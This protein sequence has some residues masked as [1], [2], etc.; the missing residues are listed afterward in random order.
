MDT[1]LDPALAIVFHQY[2]LFAE[3]QYH[4]ILRSPEVSRLQVYVKRKKQEIEQLKESLKSLPQSNS[5]HFRELSQHHRKAEAQ[6]GEDVAQISDRTDSQRTFLVQAIEMYSRCLQ[7]SDSFDDSAV[8]RLCSLWFANFNETQMQS[9]FNQA[10]HRVPSHKFIFLAHQLSARLSKPSAGSSKPP[11]NQKHLQAL[12]VRMCN[13]HPFHSLY[14]VWALQQGAPDGGQQKV[15]RHSTRGD[16]PSLHNGRTSAAADI[17]AICRQHPPNTHRVQAIE[18][19]CKAYLEWAKHPLKNNKTLQS[20]APHNM[21]NNLL[22]GISALPVP[23]TTAHTPLDHSLRYNNLV[24]IA[25]Y[26]PTFTLAGGVNLPKISE[27]IGSDGRKYK[28]LVR[29]ESHNISHLADSAARSSRVKVT[30]T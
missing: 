3:E 11:D 29:S 17:L 19:L 15:R 4:A 10:L 1:S 25:K 7:A 2:A 13:E 16:S 6:Y 23:V 30:M 24:T 27:C 8:I 12:I 20:K 28:Q 26:A 21:P 9:N 5:S 22:R 18:L 14:Q